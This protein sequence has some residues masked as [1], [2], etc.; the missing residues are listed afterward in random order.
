MRRNPLPQIS[1]LIYRSGIINPRR[2]IIRRYITRTRLIQ[3]LCKSISSSCACRT[4]GYH[5]R[6]RRRRTRV[7]NR[8]LPCAGFRPARPGSVVRL[9]YSGVDDPAVSSWHAHTAA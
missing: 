8:D 5:L 2:S 7:F 3:T 4:I 1:T 6:D 9:H